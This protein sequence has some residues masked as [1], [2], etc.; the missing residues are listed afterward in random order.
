[1]KNI[2]VKSTI[3]G[4]LL[5]AVVFLAMGNARQATVQVEIVSIKK[6]VGVFSSWD[7]INTK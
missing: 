4:F 2:D 5:C 3:I 6:P 1:M 7:A